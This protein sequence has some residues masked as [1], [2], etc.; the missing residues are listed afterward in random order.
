MRNVETLISQ[1]T[2]E[3][4]VAMLCGS[5]GMNTPYNDRLGILPL[6][7]CDGPHGVRIEGEEASIGA[8]AVAFPCLSALGATWNEEMVY[9]VGKALA[10][11]C[12]RFDKAMLL[13]PGLNM[14]RTDLCGR[15]F[16]YFS[17]DPVLTGVLGAAY[18]N[19][20][21]DKGVGACAK[22]FA[23][24]NQETDRLYTNAEIDERT[25]R[26]IYLK[27]FEYVVRHASPAAIM[28]ALNKVN[29]VLCSE[30]TF[31]YD[32]L[33]KE[34]GY[35]GFVMSDWGCC[36]DPAR[37]IASGLDLA[38][39]WKPEFAENLL[40]S[41]HEGKVTEE[42]IDRAVRNVLRFLLGY[43][44]QEA[45]YTREQSHEVCQKAAEE[46]IVL[47]KNENDLLPITPEKYKRITVVGAFAQNPVISGYGSA[48]VFPGEGNVES[49]LHYIRELAGDHIRVD[50]LPLYSTDIY[51]KE[52]QFNYYAALESL[53]ES[54]LVLMFAGREESVETE[55]T[56]RVSSLLNP[57]IEFFIKEIFNKNQ[58]IALIVQS[59]GAFQELNWR[60]KVKAIVQMWFSG[61]AGGSAI[62][63]VLFGCVNPSGKL[64][65]T[66]AARSR[67][68]LDF[69]GDGYK[70]CYDEKWRVGYRYYDLH[71]E[72]IW[73]PFGYGLSFTKFKLS[74][75][76]LTNTNDGFTISCKV[77]NIGDMAGKEVV[78]VYFSDRISTASR[79]KKELAAFK[80]TR[81]LAPG[82]SQ[83]LQFEIKNSELAYYNLTFH[84]WIT[85]PGTY[86]IL[87]GTSSRDIVLREEYRYLGEC[88]YTLQYD[89][90]QIM[91]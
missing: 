11:E 52:S 36:K 20:L 43:E 85:E 19:G 47:L 32:I 71:P 2:M 18:I 45:D 61:E 8:D 26:E 16:E 86:D 75:S 90:E 65:E 40:Q 81:L 14:K 10:S 41:C 76:I 49:P 69:P 44:K 87:V 60:N 12:I 50:Y 91:G 54:D 64:S 39:P 63:N 55:G 29:S 15:N 1:M 48:R 83:V 4:K 70:V 28:C 30:N 74:D 59:G 13:G 58:N 37:S 24:N 22:H 25:L 31:L 5:S 33:K 79:P 53:T 82:E 42:E 78:Q 38:M 9:E 80:K 73:Y 27:A 62:A 17:E 72:E 46:A 84:R 51:P 6:T 57:R 68:D 34:W 77:T 56:D 23:V 89:A 66:F 3:E 35:Q 67:S 7:M 88:A 21:Q